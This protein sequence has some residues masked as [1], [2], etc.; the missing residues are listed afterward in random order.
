MSMKDKLTFRLMVSLILILSGIALL[1]IGL[2]FQPKGEIHFSVL[3]A[4]GEMG[5]LAGAIMGVDY[6]YRYK[7]YRL[8]F[9]EKRLK[10]QEEERTSADGD[11]DKDMG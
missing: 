7:E 8:D 6:H 10:M 1:T 4:F 5:T 11:V 2:F 3:S 9:R